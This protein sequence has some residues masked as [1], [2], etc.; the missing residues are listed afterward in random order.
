VTERIV[1]LAAPDFERTVD[2]LNLVFS[3]FEPI[4]FEQAVPKLYRPTDE[5]MARHVAVERDGHLLAVA[6][7]FPIELQV[8]SEQLRVGG[9]GSVATHP[10]ERDRG[11]MRRLMAHCLESMQRDGVQL[12]WLGGQRQR[13]AHH[14]YEVCGATWD[15]ELTRRN[16]R[17]R[18]EP[19]APLRFERICE[20]DDARLRDVLAWH[21]RAPIHC[22]RRPADLLAIAETW[23]HELYLAYDTQAGDDA[24]G[25]LV[26]DL[27]AGVVLEAHT[28]Q[29]ADCGRL[30]REW[31]R[32]QARDAIRCETAPLP[33]PLA[34]ALLDCAESWRVRPCGNWRVFDWPRTVGAL[35]RLKRREVGLADGEARIEVSGQGRWRLWVGNGDAGCEPDDGTPEWRGSPSVAMR[36]LFGP[37]PPAAAAIPGDS[38]LA[39][40][41]P[42]PLYMPRQDEV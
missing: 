23:H 42:L 17:Y 14:G 19:D 34:D 22:R 6:G 21:D 35:L 12:S 41:C 40:W 16:L 11:H 30:V 15:F 37:L 7:L 36:A 31:L 2:L 38:P 8:G 5:A 24:I 13:Y 10:R 1:Q 29:G 9:I 28:R 25:Y 18:R 3:A 27:P 20:P 32:C 33:S 26:A 4:D 39:A